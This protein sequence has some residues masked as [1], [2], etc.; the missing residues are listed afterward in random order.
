MPFNFTL[1][2]LILKTS[3]ADARLSIKC[4]NF[5]SKM[6]KLIMLFTHYLK[7]K[8]KH[9]LVALFEVMYSG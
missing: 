3:S 6:L 7:F 8:P 2:D 9:L 4:L 1:N 5:H